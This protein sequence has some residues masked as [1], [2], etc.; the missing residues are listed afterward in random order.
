VFE[1]R[2]LRCDDGKV[3]IEA[4]VDFGERIEAKGGSTARTPGH[5]GLTSRV[6]G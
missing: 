5:V 3:E 6:K 4:F 1:V 2:K